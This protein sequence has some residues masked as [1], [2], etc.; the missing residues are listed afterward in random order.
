MKKTIAMGETDKNALQQEVDAGQDSSNYVSKVESFN[1]K[2][3]KFNMIYVEGGSF[4]MGATT[5]QYGDAWRHEQPVHVVTL[6][7]YYMAETQVT[8]GLWKAVMGNRPSEFKKGDNYPVETVSWYDIQKFIAK[9]ND[10]TGKTFRLPTEAEWEYA[11]RGGSRSRGYKYS[12]SDD[13]REVA[14]Y[15]YKDSSDPHRT[16]TIATTMPV[17][18]LKPNELGIYDMSGNVCEWCQDWYG[19]HRGASQTNP[20]GP[21]SGTSRVLRG[22]C[23]VL[24]SRYCR[25]STRSDAFPDLRDFY[26]GFRLAMMP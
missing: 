17:M 21:S 23:W 25:V 26:I 12:G 1:V 6:S 14:W 15:G 18:Q 13:L 20:Q 3:V 16:S 7:D 8:Q 9:L 10:I 19:D 2:G 4:S 24:G 5:E 22:G 11:A